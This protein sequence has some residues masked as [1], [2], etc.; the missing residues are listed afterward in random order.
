MAFDFAPYLQR[1]EY[2]GA[3]SPTLETLRQLQ[4]AHV[5]HIPFENLDVL[6]GR[7]ILLDH[8]SISLYFDVFAIAFRAKLNRGAT[9]PGSTRLALEPNP[10]DSDSERDDRIAG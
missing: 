10:T 1:I 8:E 6:L 3:L 4:F 2:A 9:Q 7:P 5:Q